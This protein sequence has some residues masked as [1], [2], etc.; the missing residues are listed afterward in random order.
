MPSTY[1]KIAT[2]TLV[3]TAP[4]ITFTGISQSY[5]DLV[6]IISARSV[7]SAAE[8]AGFV[9]VGNGSI[10]TG[11]NYSR[12]RLLGTGTTASSATGSNLTAISWDSLPGATSAAGNFCATIIQIMNYSN[13]TTYKSFLIRANEPNNYVEAESGLWRSTSAIDQVRIYGDGAADL[14]IGTVITLYGIEAA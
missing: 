11:S 10:D 1:E 3:S 2:T 5:T 7:F 4:D 9:R 6:V 8:V 12:I 13:T 14:A